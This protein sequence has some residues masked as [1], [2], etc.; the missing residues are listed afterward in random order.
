MDGQG[1]VQRFMRSHVHGLTPYAGIAP[2]A[3]LAQRAGIAPEQVIKLDGNENPYGPSPKVAEALAAH[4]WHHLYPDPLQRRA[5]QALA[6]Y[7]GTTPEWVVAGSGADELIDLLVRLFIEPGEK[8]LDL[9]PTFGMYA[10]STR[11]QGGEV[12]DVP[13]DEEFEVDVAAVR[14]AVDARTK[15]VFLT[16]PNNPTGAL[17]SEACVRELLETGLVVVVDE[18]Y[19]EFCGFTVAHLVPE[20]DN[21][22][23][24]RTLS[25]WA[26]LAGLRLGYGI[27][28]PELVR[29]LMAIKLPYNISVA[30]EAALH[31]SLEDTDLLLQ[32]VRLLVE[33]RERMAALLSQVPG[34]HCFPSKGNFVLCRF[35]PDTAKRVHSELADRGIFVRHF[36]APRLQDCLRISAGKPAHTDALMGALTEIV[37]VLA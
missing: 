15:L 28:S 20:Y 16:N 34:V 27:M 11:I 31:A 19:H 25:K 6:T 10:V 12:V 33:E 18:T 37:G 2:P 4:P 8:V 3:F 32:R 7:V 24:L 9:P 23:V 14:E 29:Y 1:K 35:P 21:L 36:E 30:A 26:G 13:R 22:I 5:R 17:S